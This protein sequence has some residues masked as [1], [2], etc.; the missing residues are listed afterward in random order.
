MKNDV[1]TDKTLALFFTAGVSLKTWHDTGMIEREVA[2][3]NRLSR[4]FKQIYFFTYGNRDDL[5]FGHYLAENIRVIPARGVSHFALYSFLLPFIHRKILKN[6]DIFKT[7]QMLGSWSAVIAKALYRK[8]LVVRTG[9]T[10]SFNYGREKPKSRLRIS[11]IRNIERLAY[12]TADTAITSSRWS[13]DYLMQRYRLRR[14]TVIPNYVDTKL[15]RPRQTEKVKGSICFIGR[16]SSEKNL[17]ALIEALQGLPYTLDIIG[18]GSQ[19]AELRKLA[20][21]AGASVNFLGSVPNHRLPDILNT[22][23]LFVL[24]SLWEGMPKTLLEA[25]ACGLPVAGTRVSGITEV[26]KHEEN[27][28]L[29]DTDAASIR[30]ALTGIMADEALRERLGR[31]ARQTIEEQYSLDKLAERELEI[32]RQLLA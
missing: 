31:N 23:E 8:K 7:N 22:H 6:A 15:F 13:L 10:W 11:I 24:P 16:L 25:M 30:Q 21:T 5:E 18:N 1:L 26:I 3:Y 28:I 27:G 20:A 12:R 19:E 32:Y 14:H 4:Y 17:K 2:I 9:Y 29:C